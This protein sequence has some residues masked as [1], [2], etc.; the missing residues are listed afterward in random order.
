MKCKNFETT[1]IRTST[2]VKSTS[3][4][5]AG[6]KRPDVTSN[7]HQFSNATYITTLQLE[8][9]MQINYSCLLNNALGTARP[10]RPYLLMR[11]QVRF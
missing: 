2:P 1:V 4:H 9:Y 6:V 8:W 11:I 7:K 10:R 5:A 3:W